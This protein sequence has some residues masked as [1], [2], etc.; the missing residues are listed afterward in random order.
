MVEKFSQDKLIELKEAFSIFDQNGDGTIST[1]EL[2]VVIRS[3]G[4]SPTDR[5]I[6]EII[7]EFDKDKSGA[8]E[9]PEFLR[10][11]AKKIYE[12]NAKEILFEAFKVFDN[13]GNG[14]I[15][16]TELRHV[17]LNMPEKPDDEEVDEMIRYADLDGDG[18]INYKEFVDLLFGSTSEV[19]D[20]KT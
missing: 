15:S 12:Q 5:E 6:Q 2:G 1:K 16:A 4:L 20:K 18:H 10:L 3:L 11:M 19:L 9:Y 17:L 8:L 14:L 7:R 13:D